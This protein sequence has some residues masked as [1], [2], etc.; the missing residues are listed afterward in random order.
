[1]LDLVRNGNLEVWGAGPLP[2]FMAAQVNNTA[3]TI[4]DVRDPPDWPA[5]T[6]FGVLVSRGFRYVAEGQQSLRATIA[7]GGAVDAFRLNPLN[8]NP[9]THVGVTAPVVTLTPG[10][11]YVFSF[12]CR[13]SQANNLVRVRLIFRDITTGVVRL[14]LATVDGEWNAGGATFVDLGTGPQWQRRSVR[15]V[16][17]ATDDAGNIIGSMIWQI[18]NG[19]AAAQLLDLD[20]IR[21]SR[22]DDQAAE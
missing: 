7:A 13:C 14:S 6:A 17:P 18:S 9:V 2:A 21:L 19:T 20:D 12:E 3:I 16:A 4:L 8:V 10:M 22:S 1:M 5:R 15:F 11:P